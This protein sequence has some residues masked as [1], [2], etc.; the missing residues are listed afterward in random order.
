MHEYKHRMLK[1]IGQEARTL[2]FFTEGPV[3]STISARLLEHY[4]DEMKADGLIFEHEAK[5][6]ITEVGRAE[7]NRPTTK[8][9]PRVWCSATI[10]DHYIPPPRVSPRLGADQHQQYRSRGV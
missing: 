10:Q 2:L 9:E 4:L 5:Y 6:Y 7:L 8:A 1:C 3:H